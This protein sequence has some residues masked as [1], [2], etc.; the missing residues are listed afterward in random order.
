M[1]PR[2]GALDVKA[3]L[4]SASVIDGYGTEPW[5]L[6]QAKILNLAHEIDDLSAD[7]LI[8]PA[9]HPVIPAYATFTVTSYPQSPVGAFAIAEV[10]VMGRG[11]VRPRGFVLRSFVNN[12]DARRELAARWGYPVA[13]GEIHLVERHDRV[14][15]RVTVDGKTALEIEL[16]DRDTI[17]GGDIQYIA[18]MHLARSGPEQKGVLVQCDPEFVFAKAERG[19]PRLVHCDPAA[20]RAGDYLKLTNPISTTFTTCDVTLPKIRYISDPDRPALQGTTKVAA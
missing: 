15:A 13:A 20:W 14:Q 9:M 16:W 1:P 19:R 4:A 5:I 2:F 11:G 10:R 3:W 7:H 12:A 8:P 18:S 6:K 17:S